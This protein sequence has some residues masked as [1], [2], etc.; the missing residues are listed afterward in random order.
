MVNWSW[1]TRGEAGTRRWMQVGWEHSL[2]WRRRLRWSWLNVTWF[3]WWWNAELSWMRCSIGSQCQCW[4][5]TQSCPQWKTVGHG[6]MGHLSFCFCSWLG[7]MAL[8]G[9]V[10]VSLVLHRSTI[11]FLVDWPGQALMCDWPTVHFCCLLLAVFLH[12]LAVSY[13]A[14]PRDIKKL[15]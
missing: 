1:K 8:Q 5:W 13:P 7:I 14:G 11:I 2:E 10:S 15:W 9:K 6:L 12:D 4:D 3:L